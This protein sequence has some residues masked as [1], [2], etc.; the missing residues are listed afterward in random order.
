MK[1]TEV[2]PET[3]PEPPEHLT[4]KGK[5][6]F[7]FYVGK[8]IRAPGQIALLVRGLEAMDTADEAGRVIREEG[9]SVRS[10][11]SGLVRQHPLLNTQREATAQMLKIWRDL[12][13]NIN[14]RQTVNGFGYEN[15]F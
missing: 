13:L 11:R 15:I 8:T 6:L 9:L 4:E 1:K 7:R 12:H 14:R 10:E 5:N 2:K 3:W